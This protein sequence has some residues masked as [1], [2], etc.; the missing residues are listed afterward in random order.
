MRRIY[1]EG[2]LR[3]CDIGRVVGVELPMD[4]CGI[5]PITPHLEDSVVQQ[6]PYD[7][8]SAK[9]EKLARKSAAVNV[10]QLIGQSELAERRSRQAHLTKGLLK[11]V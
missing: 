8:R 11:D 2:V 10:A 3:P 7:H 6:T 9:L 4:P 5:D 1:E